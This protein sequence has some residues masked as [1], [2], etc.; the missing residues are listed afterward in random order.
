MATDDSR[1]A[2]P[3]P[4]PERARSVPAPAQWPTNALQQALADIQ[5][6]F[7]VSVVPE[8]DSTNSELMRRARAGHGT[9]C[10]LVA[11]RQMA[12]RGRLGRPWQSE[13]DAA[14]ANDAGAT[15]SA[16]TFSLGMALAPACWSGLSLAVGVTVAQALHPRLGL[17][18]PNDLWLDGRKMAGILIETASTATQRYTVIGIG[19]NIAPRAPSALVPTPA[20]LQEL[21]PEADPGGALL[22][23]APS[24]VQA[25]ARFEAEGFGPFRE[26]FAQR[27]V[28][29]G[30]AVVLSDGSIGVAQGV[31]ESG[32]LLVHTAHGMRVVTSAEVSVRPVS[33]APGTR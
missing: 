24:L 6:G 14:G 25:I 30:R 31:D 4:G 7:E 16:L 10:L 1:L 21:A 5:G 19:V 2:G 17:K 13:P 15:P 8:L 29:R 22:Q 26:A 32:A 18:W 12:G 20:W 33:A 9:P 3:A 27:D 28:L 23:I 11:V